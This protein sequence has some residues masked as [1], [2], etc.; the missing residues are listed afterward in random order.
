MMTNS[1]VVGLDAKSGRELWSVPFPDDRH[2]NITT[3]VRTGAH[4]VVSGFH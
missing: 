4:L 3:P 2:E 1:S